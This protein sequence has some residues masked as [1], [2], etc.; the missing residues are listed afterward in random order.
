[1]KDL[2]LKLNEKGVTAKYTINRG[3][4]HAR[5][6]NM[7]LAEGEVRFECKQDTLDSWVQH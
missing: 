6:M 4:T 2:P 1:V 7:L 5:D 3:L